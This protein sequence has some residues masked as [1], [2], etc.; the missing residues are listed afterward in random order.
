[1]ENDPEVID[2]PDG[3]KAQE[4]GEDLNNL[5]EDLENAEDVYELIP[6]PYETEDYAGFSK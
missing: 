5:E 4:Y 1:M 2:D 6:E 3:P